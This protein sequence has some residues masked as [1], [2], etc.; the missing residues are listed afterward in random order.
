MILIG[1][2]FYLTPPTLIWLAVHLVRFRTRRPLPRGLFYLVIA[3][4]V[5]W[6]LSII[7][8]ISNNV[9]PRG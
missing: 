6:I 4:V 3:V 5:L 8:L 2:L 1:L 7:L 9:R